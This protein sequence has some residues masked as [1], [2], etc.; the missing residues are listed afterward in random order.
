MYL[1]LGYLNFF[2]C[3]CCH[4][5]KAE[6]LISC[7]S[8]HG[9]LSVSTLRSSMTSLFG[10]RPKVT[11]KTTSTTWYAASEETW[12]RRSRWWTSSRIQSKKSNMS[13]TNMLWAGTK[14]L[15]LPDPVAKQPFQLHKDNYLFIKNANVL[16]SVRICICFSVKIFFL[17]L[18]NNINLELK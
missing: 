8:P 5:T 15:L 16:F 9:S 10:C 13:D 4:F 12:W 17:N 1:A 11:Q 7:F 2:F 18:R 3:F 6:T 14:R